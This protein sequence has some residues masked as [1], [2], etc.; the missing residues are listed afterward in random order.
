MKKK[1]GDCSCGKKNVPVNSKGVC[2][3]CVYKKNH[4]GKSKVEVRIERKRGRKA[5]LISKPYILPKKKKNWSSKLSKEAKEERK[6]L[7]R[8]EDH[9]FYRYLFDN[10][11]HECEECGLP[12]PDQFSFVDED[13]KQVVILAIYQYSHILTKKAFPEFRW[14]KLN[15]NRLCKAHH[16]QWEFGERETMKI[17]D[18]NQDAIDK[19]LKEK[20]ERRTEIGFE[21]IR[22]ING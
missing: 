12:L 9:K 17:F 10:R 8:V 15:A 16:H 18:K 2:P 19:M 6:R 22:R 4:G 14:H 1:F 20:N 5:D 11:P 7:R 13:T 21:K 3:D